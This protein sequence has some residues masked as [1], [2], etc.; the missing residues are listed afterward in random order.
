MIDY[1]K[2]NKMYDLAR[3]LFS[4][5]PCM[6]KCEYKK[7]RG[8]E[9]L[10]WFGEYVEDGFT[11]YRLCVQGSYFSFEKVQYLDSA[12]KCVI[13]ERFSILDIVS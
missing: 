6:R 4:D 9:W 10:K 8:L 3:Y 7:Y 1:L 2:K 13:L 11:E 5:I 12:S